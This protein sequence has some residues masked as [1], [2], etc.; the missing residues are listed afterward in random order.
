MKHKYNLEVFQNYD[1]LFYYLLGAF[2]TDGNVSIGPHHN[3]FQ[4]TSKDID[5]LN[6]I[7]KIINCPIYPT[8]DG[9]G[10]LTINSKLICKILIE[11]GC[12]PNKSLSL[13]IPIIPDYYLRDFLRGCM[14]GDGSISISSGLQC[15]L[16]SSSLN[17]I[18]Q[19]NSILDAKNIKHGFCEIKKT[20]YTLKNGKTI[21]PK[22]KHYR[23][24]FSNNSATKFLQWLYY[25]DHKISMPRKRKIIESL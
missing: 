1:D 24:T 15:Y 10:N 13:G 8:K 5:W 16:C 3:K 18:K 11:Y 19:L 2:L 9:H 6:N 14:D 23:I 22:N 21:T 20:P 12:V 25:P 17:F 7:A 4:M